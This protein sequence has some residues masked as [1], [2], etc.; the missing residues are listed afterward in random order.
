MTEQDPS[1]H[2]QE[3]EREQEQG[4]IRLTPVEARVLACLME[5]QRTTPDQYPLTLNS[6]TTAC[7]QKSSRHPVMHLEQGEVGHTVNTLRDRDLI[8]ASLAGRVERYDHRMGGTLDLRREGLAVLAV[9][10]LRGPQTLGEIRTNSARLAELA[11]L[12]A[13]AD[14]VGELIER[15]PPLVTELPRSPG[16]R[17][18]RYAHLLS[19]T[20]APEPEAAIAPRAEATG[21]SADRDSRIDA[22]EQELT[23]LREEVER[24]WQLTGLADRR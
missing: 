16:R 12:D 5:K 9:L 4:L 19:G 17:E 20:P 8:H 3:Q 11:S 18:E 10:M 21:R 2:D 15:T 7:N 1:N 22:L 6:L 13:V 23:R 14:L 24:L